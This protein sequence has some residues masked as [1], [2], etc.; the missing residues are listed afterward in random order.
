MTG[1]ILHHRQ[2][3]PGRKLM[4]DSRNCGTHVCRWGFTDVGNDTWQ[5]QAIALQD[6]LKGESL[7]LR[8]AGG[9]TSTHYL[10]HYG[11]V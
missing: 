10:T 9:R 4:V 11:F 6:I 7:L 2:R 8:Y 1:P 5:M 3:T